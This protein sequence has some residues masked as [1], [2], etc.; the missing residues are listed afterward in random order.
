MYVLHL[1]LHIVTTNTT[2][3]PFVQQGG[4]LFRVM[5]YRQAVVDAFPEIQFDADWAMGE[6]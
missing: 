1:R 4:D 6:E 5:N 2:L 3:F